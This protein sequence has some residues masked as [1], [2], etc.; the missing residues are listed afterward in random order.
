MQIPH[1]FHT[2]H[3][4]YITIYLIIIVYCP[5]VY[6]LQTGLSPWFNASFK[7]IKDQTDF[8]RLFTTPIEKSFVTR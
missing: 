6:Q 8:E 2:Y 3:L 5:N 1:N 7:M 4:V